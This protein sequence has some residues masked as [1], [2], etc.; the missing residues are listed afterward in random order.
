M[1]T[2]RDYD[3]GREVEAA[4]GKNKK[5]SI[6]LYCYFSNSTFIFINSNSISADRLSWNK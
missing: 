1:L 4:S 5:V 2:D 6:N 3:I